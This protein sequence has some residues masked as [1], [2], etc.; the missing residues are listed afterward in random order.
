M[1]SGEQALD[2]RVAELTVSDDGVT[3]LLTF[4]IRELIPVSLLGQL[5]PAQEPMVV[6]IVDRLCTSGC[7]SS[8][9]R[10]TVGH[11]HSCPE[12]LFPGAITVGLEE[13]EHSGFISER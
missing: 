5:S 1:Q 3:G 4:R 6:N 8:N 11:H 7:H 10:F 9:T 12:L 13:S 2:Q